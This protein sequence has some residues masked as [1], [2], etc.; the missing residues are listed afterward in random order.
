M[1]TITVTIN[2]TELTDEFATPNELTGHYLAA[3]AALETFEG[4]DVFVIYAVEHNGKKYGHM[5]W[6]K[7]KN[8]GVL[9]PIQT[10]IYRMRL[11]QTQ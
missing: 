7:K 8:L 6:C 5:D 1:G 10:S 4:E 11:K 2:G 9:I 3:R